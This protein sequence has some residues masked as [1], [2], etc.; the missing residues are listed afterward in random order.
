MAYGK[1]TRAMSTQNALKELRPFFVLLFA[2][3][4]IGS[5][6]IYMS[7]SFVIAVFLSRRMP[8]VI[9]KQIIG[10][11][12]SALNFVQVSAASIDIKFKEIHNNSDNHIEDTDGGTVANDIHDGDDKRKKNE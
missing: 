6:F 3:I 7:V 10:P 9:D 8:Y 12:E 4:C 2:Y 5:A 11:I 1:P